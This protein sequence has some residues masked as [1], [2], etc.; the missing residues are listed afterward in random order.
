M[1]ARVCIRVSRLFLVL[2]VL[3][4]SGLAAAGTAAAG[5]PTSAI[6]VAPGFQHA[7]AIYQSDPEYQRLETLLA[8]PA[9]GVSKAE[10]PTTVPADGSGYVTVS[11]LIHD[12]A[13]WRIDR[14]FLAKNGDPLIV[15][16]MVDGTAASADGMYPGESGND[17]AV[18]HRSS[19]PAALQ[20]LLD[21]LGL[22]AAGHAQAIGVALQAAPTTPVTAAADE[23]ATSPPTAALWILAGLVLGVG[24]TAL[25]FR[26]L[27]ALRH[28]VV[29]EP[30]GT[31][32]EP[33]QMVRLPQ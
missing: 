33:V 8:E 31:G 22:T 30:D 10:L 17:T 24:V 13:I 14:I 23:P 26:T 12:V 16:Q 7:A 29:A 25:A 20:A 21:G 27:P 5:G 18:K 28:R 2:V 9:A 4:T 32:A 11:W 1:P 19:D 15:T 6:L 3:V